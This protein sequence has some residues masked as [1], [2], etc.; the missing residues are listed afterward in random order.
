MSRV[1][2]EVSPEEHR[3]MKALAAIRGL[4]LKGYILESTVGESTAETKG[5]HREFNEL[6]RITLEKSARGEDLE[7][8]ESVDAFFDSLDDDD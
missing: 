8:F 7:T 4:T 2:I 5:I 1:S 3:K 6:T